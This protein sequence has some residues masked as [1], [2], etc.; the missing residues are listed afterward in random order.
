MNVSNP[1]KQKRRWL[2]WLLV[3]FGIWLLV[4]VL[5]YAFSPWAFRYFLNPVLSEQQLSFSPDSEIRYNPFLSELQL[6]NIEIL[7]NEAGVRPFHLQQGFI[8][9]SA[10]AFV[11]GEL[12]VQ[13]FRLEKGNLKMVIQPEALQIGGFRIEAADAKQPSGEP[14]TTTAAFPDWLT[15]NAS[16]LTFRDIAIDVDY[17]FNNNLNQHRLYFENFA[18]SALKADAEQQSALVE[19]N[20]SLDQAPYNIKTL[21]TAQL[22]KPVMLV[23]VDGN[24]SLKQFS[25]ANLSPYL[26]DTHIEGL[27]SLSSDINWQQSEQQQQLTLSDIKLDLTKMAVAQQQ[28]L[29]QFEKLALISQ[30]ARVQLLASEQMLGMDIAATIQQL[31]V[32][33]DQQQQLIAKADE[34]KLPSSTLLFQNNEVNYASETLQVNRLLLSD[35][36]DD[37]IPPLVAV[38]EILIQQLQFKPSQLNI[39]TIQTSG[40]K[41]SLQFDPK[42]Q[43]QGLVSVPGQQKSLTSP[44]TNEAEVQ[45]G[46][47]F[48]VEIK[49]LLLGEGTELHIKDQSVKPE[50]LQQFKF[51]QLTL[52]PIATA[53]PEKAIQIVA[54]G[55]SDAYSTFDI[56]AQ[57]VPLNKQQPMD[58]N[59]KLEQLNLSPLSSYIRPNIGHDILS[60]QLDMDFQLQSEQG[61]LKGEAELMLRG[62]KLTAA[63]NASG[64]VEQAGAIPFNV[65]I[66]ML[67]DK[68]GNVELT[69][70]ISGDLDKPNFKLSGFFSILVK[71][72][73]MMA[74]KDYLMH[75]FIPYANVVNVVLAAG[76]MLLKVKFS[77]VVMSKGQVELDEQQGEY[78][79]ELVAYL[80][81]NPQ[82]IIV[83]PVA[84][85]ADID[86]DGE[87][88]EL[89]LDQHQQLT[90]V[91]E[92]RADNFKQLLV[93]EHKLEAKNILTCL[94]QLYN[95]DK[96]TPGL[97]IKPG[98]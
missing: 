85:P 10:M 95:N 36:Q 25:L 18:I 55:Q 35:K 49:Q 77:D 60:G 68:K 6:K 5:I 73:T 62:F 22:F 31:K 19:L 7:E 2:N 8:K 92:Q 45:P 71:K 91:A 34:L 96:G 27:V 29:V 11:L 33:D 40:L 97:A 46:K 65:A 88:A 61:K 42:R 69:V 30:Q 4:Y 84:I 54:Q 43:L 63:D 80:T 89:T 21:L 9:I 94:P 67:K 15:I 79:K 26:G 81:K 93:A 50:Y 14:Q 58:V 78:I 24:V 38:K 1:E 41:T 59:I 74:A 23:E 56:N 20:G 12:E 87:L 76:D 44:E 32:T 17:H 28:L 64:T 16:L 13:E 82:Q 53:E 39:E 48:A 51:N 37:E 3:A 52:G 83:C 90:K 75:T 57:L 86:V 47:P 98:N 66:D 72:A 70:P